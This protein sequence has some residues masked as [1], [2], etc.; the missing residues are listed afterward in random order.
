MWATTGPNRTTTHRYVKN[1]TFPNGDKRSV[2]LLFIATHAKI[3]T[4]CQRSKRFPTRLL[5]MTVLFTLARKICTMEFQQTHFSCSS[6]NQKITNGYARASTVSTQVIWAMM[7]W[8]ATASVLENQYTCTT[9]KKLCFF[10]AYPNL[11]PPCGLLK[12]E[13]SKLRR[14]KFTFYALKNFIC[15][16]S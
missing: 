7:T 14:L 10:K 8:R 5:H 2:L 12:P 11:R 16:L 1:I 4:A 13:R 15:K 6:H 3:P 9:C